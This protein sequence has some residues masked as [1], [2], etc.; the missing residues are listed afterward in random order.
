[1][2]AYHLRYQDQAGQLIARL[3]SASGQQPAA[4]GQPGEQS[5]ISNQQSALLRAQLLAACNL[6]RGGQL[7]AALAEIK[8]ALSSVEV[9]QLQSS[10]S[11]MALGH[12]V[13]NLQSTIALVAARLQRKLGRLTQMEQTLSSLELPSG[14]KSGPRNLQA[15]IWGERGWL[16]TARQLYP[17]AVENYRQAVENLREFLQ[18][19]NQPGLEELYEEASLFDGESSRQLL[20]AD[21]T[22]A[23]ARAL[24]QVQQVGEALAQLD[25]AV[26]LNPKL[27]AAHILRGQLLQD[28]GRTQEA[29]DA[30]TQAAA[31]EASPALHYELGLLYLKLNRAEEAIE[32][33]KL[34]AANPEIGS[35][36][37]YYAS[38]GQAYQLEGKNGL[39]RAAYTRA[40]QLDPHDP[41]LHQAVARCYLEEG[42]PLA[43]VQPLQEAVVREPANSSYRLELAQLYEELG[44]LQD[45]A[46][47]YEHATRLNLTNPRAWLRN[48]QLLVK[49]GRSE[50]ALDA[51]QHA[52]SLDDKLPEAHYEVGRLYLQAYQASLREQDKLPPDLQGMFGEV[53]AE[54]GVI[55]PAAV[56]QG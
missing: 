42:E 20:L 9:D 39:A 43:A 23:Y 19:G 25:Q 7:E 3:L 24:C 36:S 52:L 51:L 15:A 47:E 8:K 13:Y 22:L 21:Y 38:L 54:A 1:L 29:L 2:L 44:W 34:A 16:A 4:S 12:A 10:Q 6:E 46:S 31:L 32:A 30:L 35:Q 41:K 26:K 49:I 33:L 27:A 11:S 18:G 14:G 53:Y 55:K 40:L 56:G 37:P 5:A 50:Q 48:G 17:Q 45:A 28:Q